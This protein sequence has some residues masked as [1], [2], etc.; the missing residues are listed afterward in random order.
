MR[1]PATPA[2]PAT[3]ATPATPA[4][5]ATP[6]TPDAR[7]RALGASLVE[8]V[9]RPAARLGVSVPLD[10]DSFVDE[11]VGLA[12]HHRLPGVVYRSLVELG[13]DDAR[14]DPLRSAYQMAA[15]SHH[16]CLM[17]LERLEGLLDEAVGTWLVL[18]GPVLVELGYGDP[19]ARLYEDLDLL[20]RPEDLARAMAVVEA[21]GGHT[22]DLNWL[23][24]AT[25]R[26]AEVPM[27]LPNGMLADLHCHV[28]I[29][30]NARARFTVSVDEL[31]ERRRY[32]NVGTTTV[33][34][35]DPVD[36]FLYLCLHGSLSGGHQLV[37]LKDLDEMMT[38]EAIDWDELVRR[39]RRWQMGLVAA[40]QLERARAVLG[41]P[42]PT[43]VIDLLAGG[44]WWH[45]WRIRERSVGFARWGAA[46]GTGR[47]ATAA[48]SRDTG[49]SLRQLGRA[50]IDEVVRPQ[51][52]RRPAADSDAVPE[53]YQPIGG[54]VGRAAYLSEAAAGGW[55]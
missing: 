2:T 10:E 15:L 3:S 20:F 5:S 52:T 16:R 17:E 12:C 28:L 11:L 37:W 24:V 35:L 34:T 22:A 25:L 19:G 33:A 26:R 44:A 50:V 6:A 27:V 47:L 36:G 39:A 41:S 23:L 43:H 29:T 42:V 32:V 48:T 49:A 13:V 54:E 53:L 14:V 18:K 40:M 1:W 7:R 21:A 8:L 9:R 55:R 38:A 30:P 46:A 51:L 45:A 31:F 4:T